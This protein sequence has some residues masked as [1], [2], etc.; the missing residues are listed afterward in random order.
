MFERV[1]ALCLL[2]QALISTAGAATYIAGDKLY[3]DGELRAAYMSDKH[4]PD[5]A[6]PGHA[7]NPGDTASY[8]SAPA[9]L[10]LGAGYNMTEDITFFARGAFLTLWGRDGG[11]PFF[12]DSQTDKIALLEG[13]GEFKN[14]F[15]V[16][17]VKIG[18]QIYMSPEVFFMPNFMTFE[19]L[20]YFA[21]DGAVANI[22]TPSTRIT[23]MGGKE[24]DLAD[25][26]DANDKFTYGVN[27]ETEFK[28][29]LGFETYFYNHHENGIDNYGLYGLRPFF[30]FKNTELS[31]KYL[32]FYNDDLTSVSDQGQLFFIDA[33]HNIKG[34]AGILAPRASAVWTTGDKEVSIDFTRSLI[35]EQIY[36]NAVL[37]DIAVYNAGFDAE[38]SA[39]PKAKFIFDA[40]YYQGRHGATPDLGL[41]LDLLVKYNL[42]ECLEL[43]AGGG[44]LFADGDFQSKDA[45]KM[46]TWFVYRF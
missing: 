3:I 1:I 14:I 34:S 6:L 28:N 25:Y 41:E 17:D 2:F 13:Y 36:G 18:R 29:G 9:R 8:D 40:Y 12:T 5:R 39:L 45:A 26:A 24:A 38:L 10:F 44:Y 15:G 37:H 33:K 21:L 35:I 23:L 46:Q 20:I 42:F 43:G 22:R 11:Q 30:N 27:T 31:F 32:R 4:V 19:R 7:A 16:V